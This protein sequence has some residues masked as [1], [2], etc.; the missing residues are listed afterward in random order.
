MTG[1]VTNWR[2]VTAFSC[3]ANCNN[4]FIGVD[5]DQSFIWYC[6][7]DGDVNAGSHTERSWDNQCFI[8]GIDASHCVC[9]EWVELEEN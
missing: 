9:D 3:C 4:L 2:T 5:E 6:R 1:K 8:D 7:L